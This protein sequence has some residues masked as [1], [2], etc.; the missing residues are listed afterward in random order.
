MRFQGVDHAFEGGVCDFRDEVQFKSCEA[1]VEP[2][3]NFGRSLEQNVAERPC[4]RYLEMYHHARH[5]V[6]YYWSIHVC[7]DVLI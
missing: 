1:C 7:F 4:V 3:L 2:R 5:I 6:F